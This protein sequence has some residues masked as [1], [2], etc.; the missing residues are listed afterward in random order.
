MRWPIRIGG[1]GGVGGGGGA[2]GAMKGASGFSGANYY[3]TA[4]GA[5]PGV[6]TGFEATVVAVVTDLRDVKNI[7]LSAY[8]DFIGPG[9]ELAFNTTRPLLEITDGAVNPLGIFSGIRWVDDSQH[10]VLLVLSGGYDNKDR[11]LKL[12]GVE[13]FRAAMVG[14][15]PSPLLPL[16]MGAGAVGAGSPASNSIIVGAA[17][18]GDGV[19]SDEE[20]AA[21]MRAILV[22]GDLPNSSY[23]SRWSFAAEASGAAAPAVLADQIGAADM[24]LAGALTVVETRYAGRPAIGMDSSLATTSESGFMSA[25]D[26]L[27]VDGILTIPAVQVGAYVITSSDDV[28]Q[29][30]TTAIRVDLTGALITEK[31]ATLIQK[32]AGGVNG[33]RII[34]TGAEL[35]NGVAADYDLPGSTIAWASGSPQGWLLYSDGTN[36]FVT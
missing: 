35:I 23:T 3:S 30:D 9:Y 36:R 25:S 28:V 1:L 22:G 6:A 33:I 16:R 29:A 4:A 2:G 10:Y 7:L 19:L 11:F 17:Y 8:Q 32:V 12:N 15:T 34:R 31:R 24:T 5:C 20:S 18:K 14:Y 26:K 21:V 27:K 13:I